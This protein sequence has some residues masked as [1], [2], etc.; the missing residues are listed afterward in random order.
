MSHHCYLLP[1]FSSSQVFLTEKEKEYAQPVLDFQRDAKRARTNPTQDQRLTEVQVL[2]AQRQRWN[3][4]VASAL[5]VMTIFDDTEKRLVEAIVLMLL[6]R[7]MEDRKGASK[8]LQGRIVEKE[9]NRQDRITK[10]NTIK[11]AVLAA[12]DAEIA[13]NQKSVNDTQTLID[14]AGDALVVGVV[15]DTKRSLE[16]RA[17]ELVAERAESTR[18]CDAAIA[19]AQIEANRVAATITNLRKEK[20]TVDA[21]VKAI[22]NNLTI[23]SELDVAHDKAEKYITVVL[24]FNRSANR[25]MDSLE[26]LEDALKQDL[27]CWNGMWSGR[28]CD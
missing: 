25:A 23:L 4:A 10:A 20:R 3:T 2:Q 27:D 21:D 9:A 19:T 15:W 12:I 13:A 17:T 16:R 7:S 6:Q 14:N 26:E 18:K 22:K 24:T 28:Q 11:T 5:A 1:G 8:L